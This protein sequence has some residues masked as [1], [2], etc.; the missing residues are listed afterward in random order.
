MGWLGSWFGHFSAFFSAYG[1]WALAA[2]LLLE[3]AG[4]PVPG[5]VAL[6]YA[7]YL[8]REGR[9][10]PWPLVVLVAA[11]AC[12]LGD[13]LGYWIGRKAGEGLRR[14]LRLTPG[15]VGFAQR[16]FDRFGA[17]T[18][19]F[20]R[21][22]AGLRIIAGPAA[23]LARMRWRAFLPYNA[24]GAVVWSGLITAAGFLTGRHLNRLLHA[25][26]RV[27]LVLIVVA[28]VAFVYGLHKIER[29]G[30]QRIFPS[31]GPPHGPRADVTGRSGSGRGSGKAG[32]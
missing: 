3:N 4:L 8:S 5:E 13:N 1:G 30:E 31:P 29:A 18:V 22:I 16:F 23:G 14:W 9:F 26:G 21:F 25:A 6:F 19:F 7:A 15:R 10:L 20:A 17:T 2:L 11:A 28:A 12:T 32:P 27:E 24:A